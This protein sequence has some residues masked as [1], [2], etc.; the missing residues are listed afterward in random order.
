MDSFQKIKEIISIITGI[1]VE[2]ISD[3][4]FL[5]ADLN[6][7]EEEIEEIITA[8]EDE[9]TLDLS[10]D[11]EFIETVGDLHTIVDEELV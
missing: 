8:V 1:D 5:D 6:I 7:T 11:S 3:K 9:F 4:Q 2:R 10:E